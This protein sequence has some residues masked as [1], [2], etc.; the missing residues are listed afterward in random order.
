MK[1]FGRP[2]AR[3]K[4]C[5]PRLPIMLLLDGLYPNGPVLELCRKHHWQY[6]IVLQDKS[7]PS[8]WEE[9]QGLGR[10]QT[11]NTWERNWGGRRQRFRWVDGI[12]YWYG[13]KEQQKQI[14]HVVICEESGG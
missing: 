7:L 13:D 12:E 4:A 8:V 6:M 2:A 14:V 10:L 3:L 1:A 5:F 9:V 11:G